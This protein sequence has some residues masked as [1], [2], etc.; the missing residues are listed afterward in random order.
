MLSFFLFL[1]L[2]S[3]SLF[4]GVEVALSAASCELECGDHGVCRFDQCWCERG[5]VDDACGSEGENSCDMSC[6]GRGDCDEET[7]QCDCNEGWRGPFCGQRAA[8]SDEEKAA[9]RA[10][11]GAAKVVRPCPEPSASLAWWQRYEVPETS[12]RDKTIGHL[13]ACESRDE[14]QACVDALVK[15]GEVVEPED[16]G[17][18]FGVVS[19]P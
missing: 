15:L 11:R 10:R 14:P 4:S 8:A 17:C 9:K 18:R 1:A 7:L 5:W 6:H 16:P 3:A 13:K 2:S 19:K 12:D